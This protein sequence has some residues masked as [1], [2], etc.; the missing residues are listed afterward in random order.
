[1]GPKTI[2]NPILEAK[3]VAKWLISNMINTETPLQS[4]IEELEDMLTINIEH[5]YQNFKVILLISVDVRQL[6][7]DFQSHGWTREEIEKP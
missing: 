6:D 1:M 3:V 7:E 4:T 5:E 2:N